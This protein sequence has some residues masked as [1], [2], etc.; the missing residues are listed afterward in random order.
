MV[1]CFSNNNWEKLEAIAA[2]ADV[3][4]D[5]AKFTVKFSIPS[6][7]CYSLVKRARLYIVKSNGTVVLREPV[8][9]INTIWL[10]I[11]YE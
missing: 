5:E 9:Y 10:M 1:F 7:L 3:S 4:K 8:N 6:K 11:M 2:T